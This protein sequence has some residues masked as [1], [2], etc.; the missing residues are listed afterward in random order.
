[1]KIQVERLTET[2]TDLSMEAGTAWW[3]AHMPAS[4]HLPRELDEP[5]SVGLRAYRMAE[6]EI[7]LEGSVAGSIDLE[8]GRC[9]ARYRHALREPFRLV[10]EPAG[11]RTPTDPEAA[12]ALAQSGFCLREELEA[13]WYRGPEIDLGTLVLEAVALALPV[14]PLCREDCAGLCPRCGTDRNAGRCSCVEAPRNSP[15]AVLEA[16]RGGKTQGES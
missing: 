7:L 2:P 5:L 8:C 12:R 4:P 11:S 3:R 10:L 9:L 15:F 6:D 1:M 14:Q 16:L 13:G